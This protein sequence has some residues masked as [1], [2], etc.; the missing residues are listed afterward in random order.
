MS[1]LQWGYATAAPSS[2]AV[3]VLVGSQLITAQCPQGFVCVANDPLVLGKIGAAWIVVDRYFTAVG[4]TS[5]TAAPEPPPLSSTG[6]NTFKPTRTVSYRS[7]GITGWRSDNDRVYQGEYGGNGNHTG[8]AFYGTQVAT[9]TGATVTSA[10]IK[11]SRV[12]GGAYAAE[13]TT[14]VHITETSKPSGAPTFGGSYSGPSLAVGATNTKFMI[15]T[16]LAQ[17]L[18]DGTWGGIGFHV[19]SGS[20]YV[21]FA[22]LSDYSGAFALTINWTR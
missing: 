18:V 6:Q 14:M 8:C 2:N 17:G 10:F 4:D 20:P 15:D 21:V 3:S 16:S 5:G 12:S 22:G 1:D 11:A 13:P 7:G 19:S 9:L